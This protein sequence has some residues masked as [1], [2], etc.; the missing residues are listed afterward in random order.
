MNLPFVRGDV[1]VDKN[2]PLFYRIL[3]SNEESNRFRRLGRVTQGME[4]IDSL[5]SSDHRIESCGV[6]I[7]SKHL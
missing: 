3:K 7:Q 1:I 4:T 6:I 5:T 2:N